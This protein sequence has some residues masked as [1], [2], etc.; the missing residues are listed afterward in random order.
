M[1]R[2]LHFSDVHFPLT[3]DMLAVPGMIH[4]KRI[5]ALVN[6]LLRRQTRFRNAPQKW[7]AFLSFVEHSHFDAVICTGD[8]TAMG[9]PGEL[10]AARKRLAP[11][12]ERPDFVLLPGN[13]D[14]YLPGKAAEWYDRIFPTTQRTNILC[15][16]DGAPYPF[17]KLVGQDTALLVLNS[18]KP[19]PLI[20]RS[21]G[22]I[23]PEQMQAARELLS[24][25]ALELRLRHLV[26]ATHYNIDDDDS[27]LHGLENRLQVRQFLEEINCSMLIH[28]HIHHHGKTP[29]EGFLPQ[30]YCAGSLTYR[31]REGFWVYTVE[32][33]ITAQAGTWNGRE[34]VLN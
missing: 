14:L 32:D 17:I 31:R 26:V 24:A 33:Q 27:S 22:R 25:S 4:P 13:H 2:I 5:L 28:G 34:Y 21:S 6:Y 29:I 8:L 18:A 11:L 1:S 7:E 19:N 10:D 30:V 15:P 23:S 20:W 16:D 12:L 9:L 3:W